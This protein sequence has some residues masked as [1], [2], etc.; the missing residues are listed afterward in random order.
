MDDT[1]YW[2]LNKSSPHLFQLF[3]TFVGHRYLNYHILPIYQEGLD[4]F[5]SYNSLFEYTPKYTCLKHIS[6]Y[7]L[8]M[9]YEPV[10]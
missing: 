8:Y 2:N 4:P 1:G 6:R 3:F 7:S 9:V 10:L 5:A